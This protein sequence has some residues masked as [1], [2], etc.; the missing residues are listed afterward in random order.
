MNKCLRLEQN[1]YILFIWALFTIFFFSFLLM[2]RECINVK[3]VT[4]KSH[5]HNFKGKLNKK[6]YIK[7]VSSKNDNFLTKLTPALPIC[8]CHWT[9]DLNYTCIVIDNKVDPALNVKSW[10]FEIS[11]LYCRSDHRRNCINIIIITIIRQK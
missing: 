2:D 7:I 6:K 4:I 1:L 8:W 11:S 3:C 10:R 9:N 5:I